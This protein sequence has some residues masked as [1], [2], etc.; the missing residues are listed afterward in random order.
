MSDLIP[1]NTVAKYGVYMVAGIGGAIILLV[2]KNIS[3]LGIIVGAIVLFLGIG[4][5]SSKNS[6]DTFPGILCVAAGI[7]TILSCLPFGGF[8]KVLLWLGVLALLIVGIWNGVKFVLG[9]KSRS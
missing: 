5:M 6:K 7:L 9:I 1:T 8:S 2:L 3:W 4:V